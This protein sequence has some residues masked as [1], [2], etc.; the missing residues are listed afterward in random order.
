MRSA[1][2]IRMRTSTSRPG[3]SLTHASLGNAFWIIHISLFIYLMWRETPDHKWVNLDKRWLMV[4]KAASNGLCATI[5]IGLFQQVSDV[6]QTTSLSTSARPIERPT[7][8]GNCYSIEAIVAPLPIYLHQ[9]LG[10]A[11]HF[12]DTDFYICTPI[13]TSGRTC[14]GKPVIRL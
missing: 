1:C 4:L 11:K 14:I 8:R 10:L 2:S 3:I 5:L 9:T 12:C 6:A 7:K 13:L